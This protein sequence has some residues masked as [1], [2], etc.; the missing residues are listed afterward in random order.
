MAD[1]SLVCHL[2]CAGDHVSL[3]TQISPLT[4]A[5][6]NLLRVFRGRRHPARS[7]SKS[8]CSRPYDIA[9][10][11]RPRRRC[12]LTRGSRFRRS[13]RRGCGSLVHSTSRP[14]AL[15]FYSSFD[16]SKVWVTEPADEPKGK[17]KGRGSGKAQILAAVSSHLG[18]TQCLALCY[19]GLERQSC[20]VKPIA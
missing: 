5:D 17:G 14:Q 16:P 10:R 9:H 19:A 12:L 2:Y 1:R 7:V 3:H 6:V 4:N 8:L 13:S 11:L 20:E 15:K 18:G